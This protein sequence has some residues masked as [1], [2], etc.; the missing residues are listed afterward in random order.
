MSPDK[1]EQLRNLLRKQ[2]PIAANGGIC[3]EAFANAVKGQVPQ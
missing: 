3:Y 1:R 2:L